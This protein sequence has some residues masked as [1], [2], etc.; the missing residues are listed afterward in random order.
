MKGFKTPTFKADFKSSIFE[1]RDLEET[2]KYIEITKYP[3]LDEGLVCYENAKLL[4][5]NFNLRDNC[6]YDVLCSGNF[7]FGDLIEAI[8]VNNNCYC[9]NL[10]ISTLSFSYEN[11]QSLGNLMR[12]GFL[13]KL[14]LIVSDYFFSHERNN[15]IKE[16]F[17]VLDLGNK[18]DLVVA[19]VHTKI[20]LI[21]SK[22]GKKIVMHGSANLR[23]SRN[24]EQVCIE[25]NKT[26]YNAYWDGIFDKI[27]EKY[28]VDKIA[29]RGG[30]L[31]DI[32]NK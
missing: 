28:K 25:E 3:Y 30:K 12:G 8:I 31:W 32:I 9:N 7:I 1:I 19:G 2:S 16:A 5:D 26:L 15:L 17:K 22:G 27:V 13:K 23:S 4:A 21:E 11:I 20:V 10:T 24:I 14:N 6:R 18:F 29:A